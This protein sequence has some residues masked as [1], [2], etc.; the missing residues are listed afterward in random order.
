MQSDSSKSFRNRIAKEEQMD[1]LMN[2]HSP[3]QAPQIKT[4]EQVLGDLLSII[5]DR[6]P[7]PGPEMVD[8]RVELDTRILLQ[9]YLDM[10]EEK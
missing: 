1:P 10:V 2:G 5:V 7:T 4:Q 8:L 9:A 3:E 6:L